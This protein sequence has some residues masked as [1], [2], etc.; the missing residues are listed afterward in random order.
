M[1]RRDPFR[2]KQ[3][4]PPLSWGVRVDAQTGEE[5]P[6][7]VVS[8]RQGGEVVDTPKESADRLIHDAPPGD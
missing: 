6:G 8:F 5:R 3:K 2:R 1:T 7:D 4:Q